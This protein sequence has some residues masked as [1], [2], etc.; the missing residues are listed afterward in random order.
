MFTNSEA[1]DTLSWSHDCGSTWTVLWTDNTATGWLGICYSSRWQSLVAGEPF[2]NMFPWLLISVSYASSL[3]P[4]WT[5]V[6][7]CWYFAGNKSVQTPSSSAMI[8]SIRQ[9]QRIILLALEL[10]WPLQ[11]N[12]FFIY[13]LKNYFSILSFIET[14]D[15]PDMNKKFL[16]ERNQWGHV[17]VWRVAKPK[18]KWKHLP[19]F[20]APSCPLSPWLLCNNWNVSISDPVWR[21]KKSL[22]K[23]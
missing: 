19:A 17:F 9:G 12:E 5:P 3:W 8:V 2:H 14:L 6:N 18:W 22:L 20:N 1:G 16:K 4:S 21:K 11:D 15:S 10:I 23:M 13:C 7:H